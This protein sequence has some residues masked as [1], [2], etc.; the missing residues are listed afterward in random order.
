[1]DIRCANFTLKT[2][3]QQ[4]NG[5]LAGELAVLIFKCSH[6]SV[7]LLDQVGEFVIRVE[8]KV[9]RTASSLDNSFSRRA[10]RLCLRCVNTIYVYLVRSQVRYEQ[11]AVVGRQCHGMHVRFLLSALV[12]AA[13]FMLD[14]LNLRVKRTIC[15]NSGC[16]KRT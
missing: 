2:R 16:R 11:V 9:S 3:S 14:R 4:R 8:S 1:M 7:E 5:L 10:E 12:R 15:L 6:R 13:S